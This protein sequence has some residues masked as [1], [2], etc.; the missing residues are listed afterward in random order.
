MSV[1]VSLILV[2]VGVLSVGYIS[3]TDDYVELQTPTVHPLDTTWWNTGW[4]YYKYLPIVNANDSYQ[5]M[6]NVSKPNTASTNCVDTEGHCRDDFGDIR[7][8][9]CWNKTLDYWLENYTSASYAVFW[10]EV[11]ANVSTAT[12]AILMYYGNGGAATSSNGNNTFL[13]FDDFTGTTIDSY[14]WLSS[15]VTVANGNVTLDGSDYIRRNYANYAN[16]SGAVRFR[17]NIKATAMDEYLQYYRSDNTSYYIRY[18]SSDAGAL[19]KGIFDTTNR[20]NGSVSE[21]T[22]TGSVVT[23]WNKYEIRWANIVSNVCPYIQFLQTNCTTGIQTLLANHVNGSSSCPGG[24]VT[25]Q[26]SHDMWTPTASVM[27][28]NWTFEGKYNDTEPHI[29]TSGTEQTYEI[30]YAVNATDVFSITSQVAQIVGI[31]IIVCAIL[32][33]IAI[34]KRQ[35]LM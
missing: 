15:G 20:N 24:N 33:I 26:L 11:T 29:G 6:I 2:A 34:V 32:F 5:M 12:S 18:M 14:K 22:P 23:D 1:V 25:L 7:F 35:E 31:V 3:G 4:D 28:V 19:T 17:S 10:V 27:Y 13:F 21:N 9:D 30:W 16:S 8:T